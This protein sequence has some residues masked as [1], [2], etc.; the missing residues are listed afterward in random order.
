MTS[1]CIV[2]L[3]WVARV[4]VQDPGPSGLGV[5]FSGVVSRSMWGAT[6]VLP[7][8]ANARHTIITSSTRAFGVGSTRVAQLSC[9]FDMRPPPCPCRHSCSSCAGLPG[10]QKMRIKHCRLCP[11]C[12]CFR[13]WDEAACHV[14]CSCLCTHGGDHAHATCSARHRAEARCWLAAAVFRHFRA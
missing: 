2:Q 11:R 6:S 1:R 7:D 14:P 5:A 4:C 13:V 9:I 8:V 3:G 10:L 12:P